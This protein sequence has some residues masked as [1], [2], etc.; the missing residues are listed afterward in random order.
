MTK[1]DFEMRDIHF[2]ATGTYSTDE[3][4]LKWW[5]NKQQGFPAS[6][7]RAHTPKLV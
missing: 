2:R 6:I 5:N 7:L 4:I 3:E 1:V